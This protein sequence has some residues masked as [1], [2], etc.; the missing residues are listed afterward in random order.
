MQIAKHKVVTIDYTLTDE[1]GQVLD[2]SKESEPL[3]YIQG[4]DSIIPG[5]EQ[6]LEGKAK[7]DA[8]EVKVAPE[9]GYGERDDALLQQVPRDLFDDDADIQPGMRFQA[10]SEGGVRVVT[11]VSVEDEQVTVDA[12]HPLAGATLKFDV[13]VVDVRDATEEEIEH[14]HVHG[15]DGHEH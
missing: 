6:A 3:S 13:E 11:V 14:G 12:N 1:Q 9:A 8:F 10:V 5:L 15:A 4:T 2:S 7:G